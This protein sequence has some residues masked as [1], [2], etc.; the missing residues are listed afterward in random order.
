M[1]WF[2]AT[3]LAVALWAAS[4]FI[5]KY[6][7]SKYF[8]RG[9]IG[10]MAISA[11]FTS[12]LVPLLIFILN[13]DVVGT[14]STKNIF[15]LIIGGMLMSLYLIPYYYA[16]EDE[17]TSL[18]SPLFQ[19][20]PVF[21]YT[22]GFIF[23]GEVLTIGQIVGALVVMAGSVFLSLDFN[24]AVRFKWRVFLLMLLSSFIVSISFLLFKIAAL[25][26]NFWA[27]SFWESLGVSLFGLVLLF[28]PS[29]RRQFFDTVRSVAVFGKHVLPLFVMNEAVNIGAKLLI[30]FATLLAPIVLVNVLGGVQP[31]FV[32]LYGLFLTV[33]FPKIVTEAID[34]KTIIKKFAAMAIIFIG[35]AFL[36]R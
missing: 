32:F 29:Y 12:F 34:Q 36:I 7:L 23:L 4:S 35:T 24:R 28:I 27:S 16:L 15:I 33:L 9:R 21:T 8:D 25:E 14:T 11:S 22:L 26:D 5:D 2:G 19:I 17:D 30:N 20:I 6:L 3:I 1:T 31:L 13:S 18:V 10:A